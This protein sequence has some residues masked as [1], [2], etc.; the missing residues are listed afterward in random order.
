MEKRKKV[1]V[2]VCGLIDAQGR[3][4]MNSRPEGKVRAGFWELPGG[5]VEPGESLEECLGRELGE[6][7]GITPLRCREIAVVEHSYEHA[8]VELHVF[9]VTE[10]EGQ[11]TAK[12]NQKIGFF[13]QAHLP[14]PVLEATI[15]LLP[16]FFS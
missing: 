16:R 4:F 2:A 10:W 12:E 6:E 8:Y 13:R 9:V 1:K 11:I 5:K 3:L 7:L 14:S 15:P